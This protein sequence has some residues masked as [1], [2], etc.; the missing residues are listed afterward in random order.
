M[1]VYQARG[2]PPHLL[3]CLGL[4]AYAKA[5][6]LAISKYIMHPPWTWT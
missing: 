3:M 6:Y 2:R 4:C 1:R 5:L